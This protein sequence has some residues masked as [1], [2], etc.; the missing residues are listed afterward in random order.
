[1]VAIPWSPAGR[2]WFTGNR[3]GRGRDIAA[4]PAEVP[5][6]RWVTET[7]PACASCARKTAPV[8]AV[9]RRACRGVVRAGRGGRDSRHAAGPRPVFIVVKGV[10]AAANPGYV[11]ACRLAGVVATDGPILLSSTT[12]GSIT[13][14]ASRRITRVGGAIRGLRPLGAASKAV[15][16]RATRPP[17]TVAIRRWH[18]PVAGPFGAG[19]QG[20][21]QCG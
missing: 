8:A 19:G 12:L 15:V 6:K 16:A 5:A 11:A 18:Q 13:G 21:S 1:M 17:A 2:L 4:W 10:G 14:D 3:Q 7:L 9:D 20:Q